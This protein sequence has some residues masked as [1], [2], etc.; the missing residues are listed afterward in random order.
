[1]DYFTI[2]KAVGIVSAAI[3]GAIRSRDLFLNKKNRLREEALF[4][5]DFIKMDDG[6]LH[7]F[8]R[9]KGYQAIAARLGAGAQAADGI[10]HRSGHRAEA[11][12]D[13]ETAGRA[14][15]PAAVQA[16]PPGGVPLSSAGATPALSGVRPGWRVERPCCGSAG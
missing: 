15:G 4:A 5:H 13:A 8:V 1:M 6:S 14:Q 7:P 10:P 2:I 9:E 16:G 12:H 3:Y 11:A